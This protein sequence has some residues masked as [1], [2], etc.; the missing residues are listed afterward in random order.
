MNAAGDFID[1]GGF[2]SFSLH[3]GNFS[4]RWVMR[5]VVLYRSK[6]GFTEKYARMLA[7]RLQC[8]LFEAREANPESLN[9]Y[10]RIIYGAGIYISGINGIKQFKRQLNQLTSLSMVETRSLR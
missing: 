9:N 6:S 10:D 1:L 4:L 3:L 2:A 5:T 7:E 8:D